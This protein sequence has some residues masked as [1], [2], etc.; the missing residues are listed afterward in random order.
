MKEELEVYND[1]FVHC[2]ICTNVKSRKR[3]E[4]LVNLKN[5]TGIESRWKISR[6]KT[7][8]SGEANPCP[9]EKNPKTHK[10]YLMEC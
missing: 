3:I 1:G 4:E 10:H 9:C 8:R 7:F 2:S 5:P 6:D